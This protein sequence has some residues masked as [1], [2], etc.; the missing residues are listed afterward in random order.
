MLEKNVFYTTIPQNKITHHKTQNKITTKHIIS[1]PKAIYIYKPDCFL[2]FYILTVTFN[3][4]VIL[5]FT[6]T[7][8]YYS[9]THNC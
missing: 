9:S 8:T 2:Y 5:N 4:F 1:K 3:T 7:D 6:Y